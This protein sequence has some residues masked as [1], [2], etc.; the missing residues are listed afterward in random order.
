MKWQRKKNKKNYFNDVALR[1]GHKLFGLEYL[2]YGYFE[3]GDEVSMQ[4]LPQAQEKYVDRVLSF[5]PEDVHTVFDVGCGVGGVAQ[6]LL[7]RSKSVVCL[8][9]DPFMVEKTKQRTNDLV[10][11]YNDFYENIENH[12]KDSVDLLLMSES[13]QYIDPERG[14]FLHHKHVRPGGYVLIADF[15][16]LKK[17]DKPYLSKSGHDFHAFV[18]IAQKY[19]FSLLKKEDITQQVAP[20]MDLYQSLIFEKIFP[21]LEALFDAFQRRFPKVYSLLRFF[22]KKKVLFLQEKY[23]HQ[24]A[25]EFSEYKGYYVLLFQKK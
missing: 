24:G 13:C 21:I 7:G 23:S 12:E 4:F 25:R 20:T 15:F 19:G 11:A 3:L 17:I 10:T 8:D 16:K 2:H 6:R 5:I 18:E 22:L 14:W 1:L 9:P